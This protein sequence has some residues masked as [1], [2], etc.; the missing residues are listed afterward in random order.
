MLSGMTRELF[1]DDKNEYYGEKYN[2]IKQTSGIISTCKVSPSFF[3][4]S[5]LELKENLSHGNF[6]LK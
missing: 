2:Y 4:L 3:A 5:M 6:V 1:L